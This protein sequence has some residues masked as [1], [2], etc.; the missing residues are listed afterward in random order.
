MVKLIGRVNNW[1]DQPLPN[2]QG[3]RQTD[4]WEEAMRLVLQL[5]PEEISTMQR[6]DPARYGLN[7]MSAAMWLE[8]DAYCAQGTF[9]HIVLRV[10]YPDLPLTVDDVMESMYDN[11]GF[12]YQIRALYPELC[13]SWRSKMVKMC[14][15]I[16][17][18]YD[19]AMQPCIALGVPTTNL[20][21]HISQVSAEV[22]G[23]RKEGTETFW[24]GTP[25]CDA[26]ERLSA[27]CTVGSSSSS[28]LE[29]EEQCRQACRSI[30]HHTEIQVKS[31]Y[32]VHHTRGSA[33]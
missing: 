1:K 25:G 11:L 30:L 32:L 14:K 29:T 9:K 23:L 31:I 5:T 12:M 2:T 6:A 3:F 26:L 22:D 17:R 13:F 7:K 27:L 8:N 21:L 20:L 10:M 18:I 4:N 19:A 33:P 15:Y 28:V 24:C 16:R